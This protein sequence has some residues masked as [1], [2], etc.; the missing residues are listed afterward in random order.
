MFE[1]TDHYRL[2]VPIYCFGMGMASAYLIK[3]PLTSMWIALL[4]GTAA[5][6][7]ESWLLPDRAP[8]VVVFQICLI[9]A[10]SILSY[11]AR[12]IRRF[13]VAPVGGAP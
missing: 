2:I 5:C 4:V 10:V 8:W 12:R 11:F 13:A 3:N 7:M 6:I 1:I 9:T